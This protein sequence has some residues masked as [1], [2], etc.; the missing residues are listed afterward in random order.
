M[1]TRLRLRS[2]ESKRGSRGSG[3]Q[4]S[5]AIWQFSQCLNSTFTVRKNS[6]FHPFLRSRI[7]CAATVGP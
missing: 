7:N 3:I 2:C 6:R 4:H 5:P 1:A